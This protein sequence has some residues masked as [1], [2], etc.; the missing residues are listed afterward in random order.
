MTYDDLLRRLQA[1]QLTI[2]GSL[3]GAQGTILLLGPHEP[4]FWPV[5]CDSP[6]RETYL[7]IQNCP[8]ICPN[9]SSD[10]NSPVILLKD[11]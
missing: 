11:F 1:E 3:R 9:R 5:L 10:E 7:P 8:N 6:S 2:F 4:G